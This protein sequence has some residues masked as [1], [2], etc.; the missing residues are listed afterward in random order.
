M[1]IA[2]N[3]VA[4]QIAVTTS[5]T[6]VYTTVAATVSSYLRDLIICNSGTAPVTA[7]FGTGA[8]AANTANSFYIP[9]GGSVVLTECQVP[10]GAILYAVGAGAAST[11]SVGYGSVV[12]V[13]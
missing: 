13:I 1:A 6:S 7:S 8:T 10:N 2:T 12:S 5:S 11:V 3:W 4:N 9:S